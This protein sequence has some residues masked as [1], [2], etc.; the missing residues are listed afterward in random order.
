MSNNPDNSIAEIGLPV[1][2]CLVL[3]ASLGAYAREKKKRGEKNGVSLFFT[4]FF[5]VMA[6]F[7]V[8]MILETKGIALAG[9]IVIVLCV[10]FWIVPGLLVNMETKPKPKKEDLDKKQIE[11]LTKKAASRKM[12]WLKYGT[13]IVLG[14]VSGI[15]CYQGRIWKVGWAVFLGV[16]VGVTSFYVIQFALDSLKKSSIAYKSDNPQKAFSYGSMGTLVVL[17]WIGSMVGLYYLLPGD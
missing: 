1:V 9:L 10:V 2:F 5:S 12:F 16:Y 3:A 8:N 7:G 17:F 11:E 13:M 15:L 6:V 14:T 4:R